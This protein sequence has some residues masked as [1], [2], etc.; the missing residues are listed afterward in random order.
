MKGTTV[1]NKIYSRLK[2]EEIHI[3]P[4]ERTNGITKSSSSEGSICI[5][6]AVVCPFR[7]EEQAELRAVVVDPR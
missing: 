2:N 4:S 6:L 1:K 5:W 3:S 7:K